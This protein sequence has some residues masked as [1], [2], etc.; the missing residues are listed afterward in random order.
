MILILE[1]LIHLCT[2]AYCIASIKK[3][4]F[5][6]RFSL[7]VP[8]ENKNVDWSCHWKYLYLKEFL[9]HRTWWKT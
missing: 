3:K 8:Y 9:N 6:I 2:V 4:L 5:C 7:R 1:Q